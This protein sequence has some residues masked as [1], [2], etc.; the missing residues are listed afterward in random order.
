LEDHNR[1]KPMP[2][3]STRLIFRESGFYITDYRSQSAKRES[4]W[5][6]TDRG[7]KIRRAKRDHE[8]SFTCH[9]EDG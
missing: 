7:E 2:G 4:P 1:E 5:K 9:D 6:A 8:E 3:Y